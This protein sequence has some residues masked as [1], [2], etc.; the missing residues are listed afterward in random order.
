MV[1]LVVGVLLILF[2]LLS[3]N[4]YSVWMGI[5][6]VLLVMGFQ[7][8]V[9]GDYQNYQYAF[10][11]A[12]SEVG[13]V[14]Y[15]KEAEYSY[16]SLIRL[17]SPIMGFHGFVLVMSIIQCIIIAAF[18]KKYANKKYQ[19]FGVLI[20]FFTYNIMLLQMKAMRQGYAVD[21]LLFAYLLLDN[22][23]YLLSVLLVFVAYGFHNSSVY[24]IPFYVVFLLL[25]LSHNKEKSHVQKDGNK[26]NGYLLATIVTFGLLFFYY[27][28]FYVFQS[29]VNPLLQGW[30][31]LSYEGYLEQMEENNSISWWIL[32]YYLVSTFCVTLYLRRETDF[33]KKYYS[34][35]VVISNFLA[36]GLFGYGNLQRIG[37]YFII[38]SIIVFPNVVAFI[39]ENFKNGSLLSSIYLIFNLAFLMI[40]SV[41][42][43]LSTDTSDGT[44]FGT[45]TFS[46]LN[47]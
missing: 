4:K 36:I 23:K 2:S 41:F 9:I 10:I 42:P 34:I 46:F 13:V 7:E 38:F 15:I 25:Q 40:F 6:F 31:L 11:H 24:I 28:K 8:G 12:G 1:I 22:K 30:E 16:L 3:R 26:S 33:F 44:G 45:Y 39:R 20:V 43:M 5:L 18:I 27:L 47:W 19:Y 17:L 32:F 21:A 14:S 37:M 29:Y 35:I